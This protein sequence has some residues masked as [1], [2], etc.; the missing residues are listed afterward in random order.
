MLL[1]IL[2]TVVLLIAL[3]VALSSVAGHTPTDV[4]GG[5]VSAHRGHMYDNNNYRYI[6]DNLGGIIRQDEIIV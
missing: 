4:S 6:V 2:F 1:L 5:A 3:G